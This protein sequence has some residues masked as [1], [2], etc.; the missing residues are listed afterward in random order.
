MAW[1]CY[2]SSN[3]IEGVDLIHEML[4]YETVSF[5]FLLASK[6]LVLWW[7]NKL[8]GEIDIESP[9]NKVH[10]NSPLPQLKHLENRRLEIKQKN[11]IN[12]SIGPNFSLCRYHF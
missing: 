7:G 12:K 6:R 5:L 9:P 11:K 1:L 10:I 4:K 2:Q 8:L 3:G